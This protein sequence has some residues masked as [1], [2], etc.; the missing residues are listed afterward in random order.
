MV[1]YSGAFV[2]A[3]KDSLVHSFWYKNELREYVKCSISDGYLVG[4]MDWITRQYSKRDLV[5]TLID[6]VL[7]GEK[8]YNSD[9]YSLALG[10]TEIVRYPSL[11]RQRDRVKKIS[12]AK[13]YREILKK[14]VIAFRQSIGSKTRN[15]EYE[16]YKS[17]YEKRQSEEKE[18]NGKI[19]GRIALKKQDPEAYY[20]TVLK[21]TGKLT[22]KRIKENY[23]E[24]VK[25][26][27]PDRFSQLDEDFMDLATGK[28][29]EI[30]EAYEYLM[31]NYKKGD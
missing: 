22:K 23:L 19:S 11:E 2:I 28:T 14:H 29:K 30:N 31:G 25:L 18:K 6:T 16:F 1:A 27:H 21:I 20:R 9:I 8:T 3:L 26:Y 17:E 5:D 24:Q 13:K 4:R 12:E 15:E 10:L 7:K